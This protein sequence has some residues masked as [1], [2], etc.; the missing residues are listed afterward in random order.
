MSAARE[1]SVA[2]YVVGA[3][4]IARLHAGA[5][6]KVADVATLAGVADPNPDARAA[7][8]LEYPN[9]PVF[10]DA[11][12]ML[13]LTPGK[14]D[15]VV[16]ATPPWTHAEL[17]IKALR[18]G[19]HVLCEKPLSIDEASA[20]DMAD[21]AKRAGRLLGCCSC[22]FLGIGTTDRVS[23]SLR[24]KALGSVYH[25]TFVNR[26]RRMRSGAEYQPGSP[27]FFDRRL[28]GGGVLSDWGPYDLAVLNDLLRPDRV[29]VTEAWYANPVAAGLPPGTIDNVEQHVGAT[30]VYESDGAASVVV[31]YERAACT[32]G[33][34]RE[35]VEIEGLEG[36]L[37]WD[38]LMM[39]GSGTVSLSTDEHDESWDCRTASGR[40]SALGPHDRPLVYFVDRVRGGEAPIPLG[41]DA[42]FN[43]RCLRAIYDS[44]DSHEPVT[45]LRKGE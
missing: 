36:A 13:S 32:H 37:T 16:V 38:W 9:V 17:A 27:W 29:T 18:T 39:G 10:A 30:L 44:A 42:L 33:G 23:A 25:V 14:D 22:R 28:S 12:E 26:R 15:I 24:D 43:F 35:V 40:F 5:A 7:F 19:R 4:V 6:T 11:D 1:T 21:E 20:K 41:D 34:D 2:V 3:G 8:A 31:T 45:V